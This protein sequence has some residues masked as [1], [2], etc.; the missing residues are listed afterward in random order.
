M[1]HGEYFEA[2][3]E[4]MLD[5][6][7]LQLRGVEAFTSHSKTDVDEMKASHSGDIKGKNFVF[8]LLVAR[9]AGIHQVADLLDCGSGSH[10]QGLLDVADVEE[11]VDSGR[12][13]LQTGQFLD[14]A[15]VG[16]EIVRLLAL[17]NLFGV[18][19]D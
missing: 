6:L 4:E 13:A 14:L 19:K 2:N 17:G 11:L 16:E 18:L 1:F 12:I 7:V 8:F 15:E 3:L 9:S 10:G 5:V